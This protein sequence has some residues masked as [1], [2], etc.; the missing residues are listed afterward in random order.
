MARSGFML[1]EVMLA[2]LL[3]AIALYAIID[4]VNRCV[5]ATVSIRNYS[6]AA[7]LLANKSH[8][9]RTDLADDM[10]DL[11]GEFEDMPAFRWERRFEQ[12][13]DTEE[14][15]IWI[16]RLTVHW[17]ERGFETSETLTEYRYLPDKAL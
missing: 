16:Q 14:T 4:G 8:E 11:D 17:E 15:K 2:V 12:R 6:V 5:V 1:L 3:L 9:L 7:T 13:D 10:E